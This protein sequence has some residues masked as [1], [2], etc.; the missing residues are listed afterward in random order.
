MKR[1][2]TEGEIGIEDIAVVASAAKQ[3]VVTST[4]DE[5]VVTSAAAQAVILSK[6][7]E[8]VVTR[9]TDKDVNQV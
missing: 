5:G 7:I 9:I 1:V 4:T 8:K 6:S 2:G 3:V